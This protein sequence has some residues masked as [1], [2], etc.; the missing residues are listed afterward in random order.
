MSSYPKKKF[1][2][3]FIPKHWK[4]KR[5]PQP[6]LL[7]PKTLLQLQIPTQKV[8]DGLQVDPTVSKPV[9]SSMGISYLLCQFERGTR[10]IRV[11]GA[12][13]NILNG[14]KNS[15]GSWRFS[16]FPRSLH[17]QRNIT[18]SPCEVSRM[19]IKNLIHKWYKQLDSH[20]DSN[21][22]SLK[23]EFL[24]HWYT[25]FN[26]RDYTIPIRSESNHLSDWHCSLSKTL[27]Q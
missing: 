23:G 7:T 5:L 14:L 22:F 25:L 24:S 21:N 19:K 8:P 27:K 9:N 11:R 2:H 13:H 26:R 15:K 1:N 20:L 17:N 3:V 4:W 10:W 18:P 6:N 12:T 16:T